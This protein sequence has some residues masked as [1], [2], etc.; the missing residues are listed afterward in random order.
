MARVPKEGSQPS[1]AARL[2]RSYTNGLYHLREAVTHPTNHKF[3]RR[4]ARDATFAGLTTATAGLTLTACDA[5]SEENRSLTFQKYLDRDFVPGIE[6]TFVIKNPTLDPKDKGNITV[7]DEKAVYETPEKKTYPLTGYL[8]TVVN[9]YTSKDFPG[10]IKVYDMGIPTKETDQ[11]YPSDNYSPNVIRDLI[12]QNPPLLHENGIP[13]TFKIM[14]RYNSETTPI[15]DTP[16]E[17]IL[18][19]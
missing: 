8:V 16:G 1:F 12:Q 13:V 9:P 4:D 7:Y 17:K 18:I 6:H 19:A 5:V 2:G 3:S 14:Q 15:P 11:Q 10:R